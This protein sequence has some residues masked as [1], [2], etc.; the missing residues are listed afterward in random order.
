[1]RKD[2]LLA[3]QNHGKGF[4]GNANNFDT[5]FSSSHK[6]HNVLL[7]HKKIKGNTARKG[8]SRLKIMCKGLFLE[9]YSL[10]ANRL[11]LVYV[12]NLPTWIVIENVN[13]WN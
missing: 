9:I 6:Q 11:K 2:T 3:I 12:I 7:S 13:Y 1:M 10:I 8:Y 5:I 4:N